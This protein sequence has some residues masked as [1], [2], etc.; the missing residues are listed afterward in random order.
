MI[1]TRRQFLK[2]SSAAT[3]GLVLSPVIPRMGVLYRSRACPIDKDGR[4]WVQYLKPG[5]SILG[6]PIVIC[7]AFWTSEKD[8]DAACQTSLTAHP[9]RNGSCLLDFTVNHSHLAWQANPETQIIVR[10]G[11]EL[12]YQCS[13]PRVTCAVE[14]EKV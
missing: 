12:V 13:S 14:F 1:A 4:Y 2:W 3:A 9:R 10:P 11:E 7:A 6:G 5:E 8:I